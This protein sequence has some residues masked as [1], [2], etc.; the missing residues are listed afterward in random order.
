MSRGLE[1]RRRIASALLLGTLLTPS[2]W[3]QPAAAPDTAPAPVP[4]G[5]ATDAQPTPAG[6]G[7]ELAAGERKPSPLVL[8][9]GELPSQQ[10]AGESSP[11]DGGHFDPGYDDWRPRDAWRDGVAGGVSFGAAFV[12]GLERGYY[13]RLEAGAYDIQTR[14]RGFILGM[15]TGLEGW[16]A[17][18]SAG[19]TA[20]GGGLPFAILGGIQSDAFFFALSGGVDLVFVDYIEK[21][22][23][24]GLAPLGTAYLG[25]DLE[26][27]RFL[28]DARAIYRWRIGAEDRAMVQL[29][30]T[31]QLTTD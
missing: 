27:V 28:A 2:A 4:A 24:G 19:E 17:K 9:T 29:G 7:A 22:G 5:A 15:L 13:G 18:D 25:F 31:V 23:I 14:R 10:V 16:G 20:G 8:A 12:E 30:G 11:P 21:W 6:V 3:A 1:S 26:G